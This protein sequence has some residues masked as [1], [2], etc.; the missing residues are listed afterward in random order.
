MIFYARGFKFTSHF[1]QLLGCDAK[2]IFFET[3]LADFG[4]WDSSL[5]SAS[6]GVMELPS[7]KTLKS[8]AD[9]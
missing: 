9:F 7:P 6:Q 3:Y 8:F 5:P 4:K 2:R 1:Y